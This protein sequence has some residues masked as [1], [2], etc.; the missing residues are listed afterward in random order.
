M[1]PGPH[2]V[3]LL[4]VLNHRL[5]SRC[6]LAALVHAAIGTGALA[7]DTSV[8]AEGTASS[9]LGIG[10][11]GV[12][13]HYAGGPDRNAAIRVLPSLPAVP[14]LDTPEWIADEDPIGRPISFLTPS[15]VVADEH[16]VYA[17]GTIDFADHA[18]RINRLTGDVEWAVPVPDAFYDSWSTPVLDLA[19]NTLIVTTDDSVIGLR[20]LDGSTR[21]QTTLA[22]P[23]VNASP[24]VTS[25]LG[26]RDRCFITD[27]PLGAS[28]TGQLY[29]IN[30]DAFHET[31]NP[32]LPG[33]IVWKAD[34]IGQTSGNSPAY[35][36]G[37]VYVACAGPVTPVQGSVFAFDATHSGP[38]A[39]TPL[40]RYDNTDDAGFFG[41]VCTDGGEVFAS[42][43]T[44][45]GD[46]FGANTVCLDAVTG[47]QKWSAPSNRADT[48]PLVTR[49]R[50]FVS[51]GIAG[52][53][54][55]PTVQAF[56]RATGTFLWDLAVDS[57]D[58]INTNG[59]RD[60]G[61]FVDAGGWTLQPLA[62]TTTGKARLVVG[63]MPA[64]APFGFEPSDRL[65]VIDASWD[66]T[67][68]WPQ[69]DE[70]TGAGSAPAF[71]DGWIFTVG[72]D[73]VYAYGPGGVTP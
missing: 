52:F 4:V 15:G 7:A 16:S 37:T 60:P 59:E 51:S 45:S 70:A 5:T 43:Y 38:G 26:P 41:G 55:F 23:V 44:F 31:D 63:S 25:D 56:D 53:G 17:V 54:S 12:W 18:M 66:G 42:S 29:C 24:V 1:G 49:D 62:I 71:A 68:G 36:D 32:H 40:W 50:V 19:T 35:A 33:A 13:T 34:L 27:F 10:G 39:P 58:D 64:S 69:L 46:E 9:G 73:G 57:W 11:V 8:V 14:P 30:I 61:E 28:G 65:V 72:P 67:S 20:V 47:A 48:T 22:E 21:W 3:V 6:V 2:C